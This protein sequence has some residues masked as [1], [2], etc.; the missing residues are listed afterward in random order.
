LDNILLVIRQLI[1]SCDKFSEDIDLAID[2][3]LFDIEGDLT[4]K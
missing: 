1:A 3:R 2:R 4:T